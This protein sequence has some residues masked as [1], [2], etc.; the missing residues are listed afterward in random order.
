MLHDKK[1]YKNSFKERNVVVGCGWRGK[2]RDFDIDVAL[3]Y[4][5]NK[6]NYNS[7]CFIL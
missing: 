6:N 7:I 4:L 5:Q 1:A 3:A 2:Q